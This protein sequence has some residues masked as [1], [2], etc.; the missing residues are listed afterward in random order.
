VYRIPTLLGL[1]S[2]LWKFLGFLEIGTPQGSRTLLYGEQ[3]DIS[4]PSTTGGIRRS[5]NVT[6]SN[7]KVKPGMLPL[8]SN[9]GIVVAVGLC[10]LLVA[11]DLFLAEH[12]VSHETLELVVPLSLVART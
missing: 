11:G 3:Q 10:D 7:G 6:R 4:L 2:D 1:S 5:S 9:L 12:V 8:G